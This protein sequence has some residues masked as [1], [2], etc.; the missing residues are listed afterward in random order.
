MTNFFSLFQDVKIEMQI[1]S[2]D[3]TTYFKD[4][5]FKYVEMNYEPPWDTLCNQSVYFR[6]RPKV[7]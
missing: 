5:N 7:G 1:L 6:G 2:T 3:D 4:C